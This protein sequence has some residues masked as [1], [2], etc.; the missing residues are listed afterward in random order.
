VQ[1]AGKL[2][3]IWCQ[4]AVILLSEIFILMFFCCAAFSRSAHLHTP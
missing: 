2:S 1:S 3:S 4:S